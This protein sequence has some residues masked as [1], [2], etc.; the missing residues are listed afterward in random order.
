MAISRHQIFRG[1]LLQHLQQVSDICSSAALLK[2][3][4]STKSSVAGG[5]ERARQIRTVQDLAR[6]K[7]TSPK[8]AELMRL[9][10]ESKTTQSDKVTERIL[11]FT[12]QA[13]S[14]HRQIPDNFF[15]EFAEHRSLSY[16]AWVAARE[17][18]DFSIALPALEN[19]IVLARK[20]A[21]LFPDC[22]S[23]VEAILKITDP[24]LSYQR[25]TKSLK[26]L[27]Y[28]LQRLLKEVS[29][30]A[31]E[32][33][34]VKPMGEEFQVSFAL[35]I[36]RDAGFDESR[37]HVG[38]TVHPYTTRI[39]RNDIRLLTRGDYQFG[40]ASGILVTLHEGGHALLELGLAEEYCG[41]PIAGTLPVFRCVSMSCHES[42]A[43]LWENEVGRNRRLWER[44]YPILQTSSDVALGFEGP[45]AFLK[46]LNRVNPG[47][48]RVTADELTYNVHVLIRCELETALL[49]GTLKPRE[50]PEAWRAMYRERLNVTVEDDISGPLQDVHWYVGLIGTMF[51][52]YV[53]GSIIA[54]NLFQRAQ[55]E[56][57][58][59]A[60]DI[61]I[62]QFRS[63]NSWLEETFYAEG[64]MVSVGALEARLGGD[65]LVP[66]CYLRQLRDRYGTNSPMSTQSD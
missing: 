46:S 10:R 15:R 36:L 26:H 24:G 25:M 47:P 29:G 38:R 17:A 48:L 32:V 2:W 65:C 43:R 52:R 7:F 54:A 59:V 11:D 45:D 18:N 40:F 50:L 60:S 9:V 53:L 41:T 3:D 55:V 63:L 1:E 13:Y 57:A 42:Q 21:A 39:S 14:L 27:E 22:N 5:I 37:V 12:E 44:Y 16:T 6:E 35:R 33:V 20:F 19:G 66:D 30:S 31:E 23:P 62:G 4:Q 8:T 56:S 58:Q 34:S 51:Q 61:S 64:V 49:E 28:A